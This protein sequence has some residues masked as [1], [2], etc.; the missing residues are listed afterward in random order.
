MSLQ[1]IWK[2]GDRLDLELGLPLR[3]EAIDANHPDVVALV[4]GP[5]VLFAVAE[6]L[7]ALTK[8]QLLSIAR[9]PKETLWRTNTASGQLLFRPFYK[10]NDEPYR[11]YLNLS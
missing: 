5:L 10:I 1:R 7:P 6:A 3:L 4:R 8:Q 11:T 2:D 9:V